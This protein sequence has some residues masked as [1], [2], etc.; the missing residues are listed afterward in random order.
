MDQYTGSIM[1]C[2]AKVRNVVI[3]LYSHLEWQ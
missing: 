1:I 3:N 2:D